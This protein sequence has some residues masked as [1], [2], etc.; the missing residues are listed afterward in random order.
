MLNHVSERGPWWQA[1]ALINDD[2][3]SWRNTT[4]KPEQND[5]QKAR[6]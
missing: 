4:L 1:S 5:C 3:D 6:K 2:Q